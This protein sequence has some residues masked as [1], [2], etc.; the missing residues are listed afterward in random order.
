MR[1]VG[2]KDLEELY[3]LPPVLLL[4]PSARER[5]MPTVWI[6]LRGS[7]SS[8]RS[9]VRSFVPSSSELVVLSLFPR[10]NRLKTPFKVF[11]ENMT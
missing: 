8:L 2:S 10:A 3:T 4:E 7:R 1:D 11:E 9:F 5:A 6:G